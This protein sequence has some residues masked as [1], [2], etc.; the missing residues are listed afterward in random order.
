MVIAIKVQKAASGSEKGGFLAF[1][2]VFSAGEFESP[3]LLPTI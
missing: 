2:R 1:P 3:A